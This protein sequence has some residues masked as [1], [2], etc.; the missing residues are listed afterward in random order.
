MER[1]LATRCA[2]L[3]RYEEEFS[4]EKA[5]QEN[6][7]ECKIKDIDMWVKNSGKGK[8]VHFTENAIRHEN[9]SQDNNGES[10]DQ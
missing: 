7:Q 9:S 1:E 8:Q 5:K 2:V 10:F 4:Y 6:W 3:D